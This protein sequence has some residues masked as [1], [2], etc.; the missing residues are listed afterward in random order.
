MK[1]FKASPSLLVAGAATDGGAASG[2]PNTEL[3]KIQNKLNQA[4]N[5]KL[6]YQDGLERSTLSNKI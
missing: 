5:S 3:I 4:M 6:S 1:L 2:P